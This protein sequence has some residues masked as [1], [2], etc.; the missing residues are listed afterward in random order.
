MLLGIDVG[1]TYTDA[2]LAEDNR[3][4][5]GAKAATTHG[6]LLNGILAA[7]DGVLDGT[8]PDMLGRIAL[9]TTLVTN[10]IVEGKTEAVGVLV[11]PGPGMDIAPALPPHSVILSGSIDH[12]GREAAPV[13]R[14]QVAEAAAGF[15]RKGIRLF[16]VVGKFSVRNPVHELQV[17]A[18]VEECCPAAQYIAL[19]HRLASDLNF[20]R[21]IHT[22]YLNAAVWPAYQGF[23][24]AVEAAVRRRGLTAP[25]YLLKADGGTMP[26]SVSKRVP[27]ETI[28]TGPAASILGVQALTQ[29]SSPAVTLDIGGTTTDAAL[30]R[31]GG[32]L[33]APRG[34]RIGASF[35]HVRSFLTRSIGVGGD[36]WLRWEH[37]RLLV[38]P[39]RKDR[40]AALGGAYPTLTDALCVLGE[41][42]LGSPERA[43][44]ALETLL[45]DMAENIARQALDTAAGCI[46]ET[47][48]DM[49]RSW[50]QEPQYRVGEML[51]QPSF[52]LAQVVG[53]GGGA[54]GLTQRVADLL[55]CM[56]VLPAGGAVAN[57]VGAAVAR[58]T[59]RLTL[60]VDT[61]QGTMTYVEEGRQTPIDMAEVN[62]AA[63]VAAARERLAE[64][65]AAMQLPVGGIDVVGAE[66]FNVV[67]RFQKTEKIVTAQVQLRPG[68]LARVNWE[69]GAVHVK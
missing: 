21:R 14:A 52:G 55:G 43:R 42:S 45:P 34:M 9:S 16:A 12:R 33:F 10:A 6:A 5:A 29:I 46:T 66:T 36:S 57:A 44:R 65:A 48:S 8:R 35:T 25:V 2:V 22:S 63:V 50:E 47:V 49:V 7:M 23:A 64:K 41:T 61:A 54:N 69:A 53:V 51:R 28:F 15:H 19:G 40:P 13:K 18:W 62:E 17:A 32:P 37:D 60:R 1:G 27:V 3:I 31:E 59:L 20:P 56:A 11:M 38:G 24:A 68:I 67:R 4:I 26:L 58:P 39:E 30:W